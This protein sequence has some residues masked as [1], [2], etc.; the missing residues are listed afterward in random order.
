MLTVV[1]R[2]D[3]DDTVDRKFDDVDALSMCRL[4]RGHVI[5]VCMAHEVG[6]HV[7]G[8]GEQRGG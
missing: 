8:L 2:D 4:P 1:N 5:V 3:L 7:L 6:G